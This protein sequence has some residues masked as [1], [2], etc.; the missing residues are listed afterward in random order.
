MNLSKI[1]DMKLTDGFAFLIYLLL[2]IFTKNEI[3]LLFWVF[4]KCSI[5]FTLL[6]Q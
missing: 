5:L 4:G 3:I 2:N 6:F 1:G